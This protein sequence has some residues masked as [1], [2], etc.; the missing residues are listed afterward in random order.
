MLSVFCNSTSS[1]MI[2]TSFAL[3]DKVNSV[4]NNL[5]FVDLHTPV[6]CPVR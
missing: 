4:L 3:V 2:V 1:N 5:C 6:M